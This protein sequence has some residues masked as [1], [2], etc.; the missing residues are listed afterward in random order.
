[1]R[2]PQELG[3]GG[4]GQPSIDTTSSQ[5]LG[6]T[7]R[8]PDR[9]GLAGKSFLQEIPP[10]AQYTFP[11]PLTRENT[12]CQAGKEEWVCV[13]CISYFLMVSAGEVGAKG[14]NAKWG[15]SLQL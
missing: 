11:F 1:M 10:S 4:T 6:L 8:F 9:N 5:I 3:D 7:K 15:G 2:D 13:L 14:P 12:A